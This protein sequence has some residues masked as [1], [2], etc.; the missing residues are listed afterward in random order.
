MNKIHFTRIKNFV[1]EEIAEKL[2]ILSDFYTR[3]K[4]SDYYNQTST[5]LEVGK[6]MQRSNIAE[7][8]VCPHFGRETIRGIPAQDVKLVIHEELPK[9]FLGFKESGL[10]EVLEAMRLQMNIIVSTKEFLEVGEY[11]SYPEL[12]ELHEPTRRR[13]QEAFDISKV[14]L[15]DEQEVIRYQHH[16]MPADYLTKTWP[17]GFWVSQAKHTLHSTE[18]RNV[19][20]IQSEVN[21]FPTGRSFYKEVFGKR[22][23]PIIGYRVPKHR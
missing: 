21:Q 12:V 22:V 18:E 4:V 5:L 17:E 11:K 10:P 2:K 19:I 1:G 8:V 16:F 20:S 14:K 9:R 13:I 15:M 3:T 7:I 23:Y 6:C